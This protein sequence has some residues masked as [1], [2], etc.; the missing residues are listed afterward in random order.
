MVGFSHQ[1]CPLSWVV[2]IL[3]SSPD[4]CL[5]CVLWLWFIFQLQ[6]SHPNT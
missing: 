4:P 5:C 1:L 2:S 6:T 3:L